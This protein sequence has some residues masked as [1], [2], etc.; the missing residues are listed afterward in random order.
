MK[1]HITNLYNFNDGDELVKKQH[2]FAEAGRS[3]GFFEMGIFAYPVET[4]TPGE[5]SKRLDGIIAALEPEDVVFVQLPTENGFD[6]EQ[7]LVGK[8]KAYRDTKVVLVLHDA[9]GYLRDGVIQAECES[10]CRLADGVMKDRTVSAISI[11]KSL[12]ETVGKI[13]EQQ[14]Q[15][16]RQKNAMEEEEVHIGF[17][18]HDK[19]GN[20]SVWVGTTMQ[21]I[22]ENTGS[23]ICFHILHDA[24]L[25]E[26]NKYKLK[27]VAFG[28]GHRILFHFLNM[29]IF[30]HVEKQTASFTIGT[31]FRIM[32]P[33]LLP[34]LSKIIYL[35][36][37]LLVNRDIK[38]LWDIDISGYC[39]AAVPDV[40][41]V[42][43]NVHPVP[44]M[45]HEVEASHY[46]NAGVLCLNL[47]KI[48]KKGNMRTQ[49]LDYLTQTP[50]ATYPDQDAINV[51]YKGETLLLDSSWNYFALI[52]RNNEEKELKKRIY[53][54]AS[55]RCLLYS[56]TDMERRY[57]ETIVHT[58]WGTEEGR[59]Q[60]DKAF[61]RLCDRVEQLEKV[62][63]KS[64]VPNRK[65]F[66]YG[67]ETAAMKN[68]YE[69]LTVCDTDCRVLANCI[70]E[71]NCQLPC[72][73]LLVLTEEKN[74][75]IVFVLPEA[76]DWSA[77]G[78][79]ENF[80]LKNGKD[81]FVIPRILP[82]NKGGYM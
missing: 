5:L 77:V 63:Q 15:D 13:F 14:L 8:I 45:R 64:S 16:F 69:L 46:F 23:S 76:D 51:L 31:M 18:L 73:D 39:L 71:N 11:Q 50:E 74:D 6:Y 26:E 40:G 37:D 22:I 38:E 27:Q 66:F 43:G 57:Y 12:V 4:D 7:L 41:T 25:S 19:T 60:L 42:E 58:P 81:F 20:Y 28:G 21:S 49:I 59:R 75:F 53:H 80:G 10:L 24:T 62:I 44:V 33:E 67:R 48:R 52:V 72:C 32:L 34:D 79:L 9:D 65:R 47:D 17:G 70:Q 56:P 3:L 61:E 54:Y 29:E 78:R 35:D 2:Q 82:W 30:S 68:L 55:T 36:A 1:I